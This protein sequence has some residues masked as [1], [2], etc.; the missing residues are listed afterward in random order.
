[1]IAGALGSGPNEFWRS[2]LIN[3][4]MFQPFPIRRIVVQST[5]K[6]SGTSWREDL[7]LGYKYIRG[8]GPQDEGNEWPDRY[9]DRTILHNQSWWDFTHGSVDQMGQEMGYPLA[10]FPSGNW[11]CEQL[12]LHVPVSWSQTA[13]LTQFPISNVNYPTDH[14]FGRPSDDQFDRVPW[15]LIEEA[16]RAGAFFDRPKY[17]LLPVIS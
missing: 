13:E 10:V 16:N 12:R 7:S 9:L 5:T 1:M 8:G 15:H 4:F 6:S 14:I 2:L 11:L 3:V 17:L